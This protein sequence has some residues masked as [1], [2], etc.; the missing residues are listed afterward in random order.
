MRSHFTRL[1]L[2]YPPKDWNRT[3]EQVRAR[4]TEAINT[5]REELEALDVTPGTP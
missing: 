3:W 2:Q 4:C 5:L 1:G